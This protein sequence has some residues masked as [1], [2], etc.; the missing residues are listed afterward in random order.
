MSEELR[1]SRY[2][3]SPSLQITSCPALRPPWLLS[4]RFIRSYR[5]ETRSFGLCSNQSRHTHVV[6][7]CLPTPVSTGAAADLCSLRCPPPELLSQLSCLVRCLRLPE[8]LLTEISRTSWIRSR[9]KEECQEES[10]LFC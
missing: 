8:P 10:R 5:R 6:P 7:A 4:P 1:E 9:S 2:S 3:A